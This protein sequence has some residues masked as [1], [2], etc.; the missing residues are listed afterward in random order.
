M[1]HGAGE[2][3]HPAHATLVPGGQ[4]LAG[5]AG[6]H[7]LAQFDCRQLAVTGRLAQLVEQVAQRT[8]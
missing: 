1:Q 7:R 2:V 4:P 3:E 5:A 6:E 8:Q